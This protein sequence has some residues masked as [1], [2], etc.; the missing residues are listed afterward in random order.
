[1][2]RIGAEAIMAKKSERNDSR[3]YMLVSDGVGKHIDTGILANDLDT[4]VELEYE[5]LQPFQ[6]CYLFGSRGAG[7]FGVAV[8]SASV[9]R[10]DLG[11]VQQSFPHALGVRNTLSYGTGR[12]SLNGTLLVNLSPVNN[13]LPIIYLYAMNYGYPMNH[14]LLGIVR[15]RIRKSGIL[16]RDFLPVPKGS[17]FHGMTTLAPEN[18]LLDLVTMAYFGNAGAGGDF[19]IEE[20]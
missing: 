16:A 5:A 19:G 20:I 7:S 3:R 15:C 13:P 12:F 4:E 2:D 1:M 8:T 10:S 14:A 17:R 6:S 11:G 9:I 18:C